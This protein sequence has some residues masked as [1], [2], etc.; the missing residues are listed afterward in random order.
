MVV[1]AFALLYTIKA[2][3]GMA[4]KVANSLNTNMRSIISRMLLATI[5]SKYHL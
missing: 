3:I 5:A 4:G 2:I 1:S